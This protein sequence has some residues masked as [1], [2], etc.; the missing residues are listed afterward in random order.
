M[1]G[2][3]RRSDVVKNKAGRASATTYIN[4]DDTNTDWNK[5]D[6]KSN[7][8][9][10]G[11]CKTAQKTDGSGKLVL[12]GR[13]RGDSG[14]FSFTPLQFATFSCHDHKLFA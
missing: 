14:W 12:R 11:L 5:Q 10:V 1:P 3:L 13:V 9:L 7:A 6:T 8:L 4:C 2:D